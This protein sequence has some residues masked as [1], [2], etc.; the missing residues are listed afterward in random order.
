MNRKLF[1]RFLNEDSKSR[2]KT[3]NNLKVDTDDQKLK[4]FADRYAAL[5]AYVYTEAA[6]QETKIL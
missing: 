5:S 1:I 2:S 3:I 4:E 6:V